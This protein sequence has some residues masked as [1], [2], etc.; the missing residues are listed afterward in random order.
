M[1]YEILRLH[2]IGYKNGGQT[3][4]D[5]SFNLFRQEALCILTEDI[6]T[7]SFLFSLF[8]GEK[9][10]DQGKLLLR[11]RPHLFHQLEDAHAAGIYI[12]DEHLL[13]PSMSVAHNLFMTADAFYKKH[14]FLNNSH[15]ETA[16]RH[17]L[18]LYHLS[19]IH[20]RRRVSDLPLFDRYLLSIL[21][22]TTQSAKIII[23]DTASY[24]PAT[25]Q[26][27]KLIQHVIATLK[28]Q[29]ISLLFFSNKWSPT[30]QNFD[31]YCVIQDGVVTQLAPLTAIPP[32]IPDPNFMEYELRCNPNNKMSR[33]LAFFQN[34]HFNFTLYEGEILGL[35]DPLKHSV[36]IFQP[37]SASSY[38]IPAIIE[39]NG[40]VYQ[41]C[42]PPAGEIACIT[43]SPRKSRIFPQMNL[44]DNVTLLLKQPMYN[45]LGHVN[46]RI[47]NHMTAAALES[48]GA[49]DIF[50]KY[51]KKKNLTEM[52]ISE[53]FLTEIA[54][55]VCL[56]P[57]LFVFCNSNSLYNSLPTQQF[58]QLLE[59][60]QA[61]GITTLLIS[62][63]EEDLQK[64]CTRIIEI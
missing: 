36:H 54:K 24:L 37:L 18:E 55:W 27:T 21:L 43:P 48:I 56:R 19:H 28:K 5:I 23:L 35:C 8:S 41:N 16:T 10:P 11:D 2:H 49:S 7:K 61:L 64:F 40:K 9:L 62:A 52:K 39:F 12:A 57:K 59:R 42:L 60:L 47:R 15:M 30:F 3:V 44:Y 33:K 29:G 58:S 46:R 22:T 17:L 1:F 31:R 4:S 32:Y 14:H 6:E 34:T 13:I 53:Q 45:C 51:Q 20:P 50:K 25:P 63:S 38:R 26:E